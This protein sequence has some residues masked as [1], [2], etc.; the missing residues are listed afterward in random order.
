[1]DKIRRFSTFI[2]FPKEGTRVLS[3]KVP[4]RRGKCKRLRMSIEERSFSHLKKSSRIRNQ[5]SGLA[6]EKLQNP[7]SR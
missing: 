3:K 6:E 7:V 1:V 2:L 5:Q 4:S